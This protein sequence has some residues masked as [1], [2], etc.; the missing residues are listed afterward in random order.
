MDIT[1]G[2]GPGV[3]VGVGGGLGDGSGDGVGT[4]HEGGIGVK[5][6]GPS[7]ISSTAPHV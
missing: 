1:G 7:V 4:G 5:M 2:F 3:G 6:P